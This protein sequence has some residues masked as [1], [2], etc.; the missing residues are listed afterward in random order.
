MQRQRYWIEHSFGV[1]KG[2]CGLSDYQVRSW[3]GWHHHV[4]MVMLANL[5]ITQE[6]MDSPDE[7][8]LLSSNDIR[9]VLQYF[10]PDRKV[11]EAEIFRQLE[12]RHSQRQDS[13]DQAYEKQ[14]SIDG[15][16]RE[17]VPS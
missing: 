4:A 17:K 14:K 1:M 16:D 3:I 6:Q 11:T 15:D 10:L 8:C 12:K 2:T 5:F 7:Y 13:I 9:E